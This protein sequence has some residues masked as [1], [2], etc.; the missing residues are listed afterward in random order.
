LEGVGLASPLAAPSRVGRPL[1]SCAPTVALRSLPRIHRR[2]PRAHR[3]PGR[4]PGRA[5]PRQRR[6]PALPA[7]QRR[8]QR[9]RPR[10]PAAA[11]LLVL[12]GVV[13]VDRHWGFGCVPVPLA[14]AALPDLLPPS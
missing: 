3:V 14:P 9:D 13:W 11:V 1:S 5:G 10:R 8:P 6:R 7:C 12:A 4:A 2:L